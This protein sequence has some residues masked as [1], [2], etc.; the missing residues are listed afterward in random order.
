MPDGSSLLVHHSGQDTGFN[1][2]RVFAPS[3][4]QQEVFGEVS[5]L[6]QSALD[7]FH[8]C[9]VSYGQTGAPAKPHTAVRLGYAWVV[10]V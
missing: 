8:V 3:T 7:G 1:F 5:E 6:V 10:R 4:T 2:C 9:I